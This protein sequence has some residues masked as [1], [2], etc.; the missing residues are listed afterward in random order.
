MAKRIAIIVCFF[1]L[2]IGF[3]TAVSAQ[4]GRGRGRVRG[5][6]LDEEG[7]PIVGADVVAVHLESGTTFT[8]KT[9]KKGAWAVA[10]LGSGVFRFTVSVEGYGTTVH[11]TKVSQFSRNNPPLVFT[12]KKDKLSDVSLPSIQDIESLAL[13]EEGNRLYEEKN[14][15]GAA[16][17]FEK[18]LEK[19]PHL[20]QLNLNL[21][22]CF[23]EMGEF[24]KALETYEKILNKVKEEKGSYEGDE[25]AA[26]AFASIGETYIKKGDLEKANDSLQQAMALFPDDEA[27][28]FNVGEIFFTQREIDKAIEYYRMAIKINENWGPP[29][30]QIGYAYL[31]KGD[32][33]AAIDSFKKFIEVAPEDPRAAEI[34]A[35]IPKLEEL[36]KKLT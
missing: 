34:G 20:F 23:R 28:A 19:N 7:N 25:S 36:I 26:R 10:G 18:F 13:F 32:Y 8:G 30:R 14:Y 22:N 24:E 9:D 16:D 33:R 12:L 11:E 17:K 3:A 1:L 35:L 15:S 4:E 21:G 31:N 6:V 5:E 27:L 2:L 29:H